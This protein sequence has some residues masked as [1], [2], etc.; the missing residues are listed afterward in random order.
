M[1]VNEYVHTVAREERKAA[2]AH[3]AEQQITTSENGPDTGGTTKGLV[4]IALV[5][6]NVLLI[7]A[8]GVNY[9][10]A[11]IFAWVLLIAFIGINLYT[12]KQL[13]TMFGTYTIS[14]TEV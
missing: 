3:E 9:A 14:S 2:K 8:V 7:V 6:L 12:A 10:T 1:L 4:A 13:Q 5:L 11:P